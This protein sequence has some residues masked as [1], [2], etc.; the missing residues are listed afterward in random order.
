LVF[1]VLHGKY[2]EDGTIQ[3]LL[4]MLHMPYVGPNTFTSSLCMNKEK[5]KMVVSAA[6][7]LTP[8]YL[9]LRKKQKISFSA[10]KYPCVIK[11]VD[12]GSSV[13]VNIAENKKEFIKYLKDAFKYSSLVM[14]EE[15]I[16]GKEF[17]VGVIGQKDTLKVLPPTQIIP[18]I[19]KF[20]D[21]K[22]KY[23]AGGSI[24]I[25]PAK[26]SRKLFVELQNS[27]KR[28]Y[29]AVEAKGMSRIDFI[30]S[31]KNE[32]LYFIE[33]NTIPGMTDVSLLPEAA[34]ASGL[35]FPKLLDFL[36]QTT[37]HK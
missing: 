19:S 13:G 11:P 36:I 9:T 31:E 28:V 6:G 3:G 18:V 37:L 29:E 27:A 32:K 26:I 25:C 24:H 1:P 16:K 21:Y 14:I 33:V 17:T 4:E 5:T 34:K 22:A 10:L 20:Y 30:W 12:T 8:R 2:G 23:Q 7:L 15:Y 35:P